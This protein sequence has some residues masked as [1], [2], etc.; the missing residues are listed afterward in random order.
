MDYKEELERI[1]D[2]VYI[3]YLIMFK[4]TDDSNKPY[5]PIITIGQEDLEEIQKQGCHLFDPDL[6]GILPA[7][8]YVMHLPRIG[9]DAID[10]GAD[11]VMNSHDCP[12][13][14]L[15]FPATAL[16]SLSTITLT[17]RIMLFYEDECEKEACKFRSDDC[18]D[19][20]P[21]SALPRNYCSNIGKR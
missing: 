15:L 6:D 13:N 5:S 16:S 2:I 3:N 12:H 8:R 19:I 17:G 18:I 14:I 1:E 11:M 10:I 4:D 20:V 21:V 7:V 9:F